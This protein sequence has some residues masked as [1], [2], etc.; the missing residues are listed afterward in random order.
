MYTM[1]VALHDKLDADMRAANIKLKDKLERERSMREN[2]E[3]EFGI[4]QEAEQA[5]V[6]R[7]NRSVDLF[8]EN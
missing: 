1:R 7:E 3:L 2:V 5:I 8:Y 4:I 6:D